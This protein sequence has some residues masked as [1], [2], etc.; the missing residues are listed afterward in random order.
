MFSVIHAALIEPLP[1]RAPE[2]LVRIQEG[3]S[4]A[5][6]AQAGFA[7]ARPFDFLSRPPM[8]GRTFGER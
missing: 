6:R 7:E 5:E 1:Y 2:R 3:N 4:P 8:M